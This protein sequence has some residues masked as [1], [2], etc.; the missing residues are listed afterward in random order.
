ML[1][2]MPVMYLFLIFLVCPLAELFLMIRV[3]SVIG[4]GTTVMLV[5]LTA[6]VG[7]MLVRIQGFTTFR[8]ARML[9]A[10]NQ[11]PAL[12]ILEGIFIFIAGVLLL[13][14]GFVT[15]AVGFLLL[16]PPLRRM[17]VLWCVDRGMA[18][19][20]LHV[21][22]RRRNREDAGRHPAIDAEYRDID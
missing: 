19:A 8:R 11:M 5:V 3:G 22:T 7:A 14:P 4:A 6:L 16:V 20:A 21:G 13:V 10:D 17:A 9:L 2:G 18:S 15:D 12:E 1:N